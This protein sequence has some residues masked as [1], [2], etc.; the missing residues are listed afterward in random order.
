MYYTLEDIYKYQYKLIK[1]GISNKNTIVRYYL[2]YSDAYNA[3]IELVGTNKPYFK[4]YE[5]YHIMWH[6]R[7]FNISLQKVDIIP[8]FKINSFRQNE[9]I[10]NKKIYITFIDNYIVI[11]MNCSSVIKNTNDI[12]KLIINISFNGYSKVEMMDK[13]LTKDEIFEFISKAYTKNNA[14]N[15]DSDMVI[16]IN[17][18]S[19]NEPEI[20]IDYIT[21]LYK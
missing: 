3:F 19:D 13:D 8:M 1:N 20:T 4:R 16:N 7:E 15:D 17:K 9:Y 18:I 11:H 6:C 5:E 10:S 21:R 14:I 2:S 12:Y